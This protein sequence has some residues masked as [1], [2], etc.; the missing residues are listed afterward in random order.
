MRKP[1]LVLTLAAIAI[2]AQASVSS[3]VTV[4]I[5]D[6]DG[7]GYGD[8]S[9]YVNEIGGDP[10]INNNGILDPG[11]ALPDLPPPN[12]SVATG[13]GDDFDHRSAA[14]LASGPG[15]NGLYYTDVAL[16][17]SNNT[18]FPNQDKIAHGVTFTFTFAVPTIGDFDYGEDHFVNLVY[19]DY[20]VIPMTA[21]VEGVTVELDGN[22]FGGIDG[23]IW[24]AYK[25]IPW[26][27]MTDGVVTIQ[28][29]APNEPYVAFDYALLDT[30]AIPVQP[31]AIPEPATMILFGSALV[32]LLRKIKK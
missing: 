26:A 23:F 25:V 24:R 7:F 12:G 14:E 22:T 17:D 27:Q 29:N 5:G 11:D 4:Y 16:S 18:S 20:D 8:G 13:S 28:I 3:A 9:P 30:T 31:I 15:G 1:T 19:A 32:A 21:V 6:K 2:L 10:D